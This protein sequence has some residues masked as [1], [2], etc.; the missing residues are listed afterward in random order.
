MS[1][2]MF[3]HKCVFLRTIQAEDEVNIA[4]LKMN[5]LQRLFQ[6]PMAPV[7]LVTRGIQRLSPFPAPPLQQALGSSAPWVT[8]MGAERE[9]E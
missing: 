2:V 8:E 5:C 4:T 7:P 3:D 1:T 6:W 9:T